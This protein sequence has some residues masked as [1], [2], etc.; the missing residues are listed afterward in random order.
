[1]NIWDYTVIGFYVLIMVIITLLTYSTKWKSIFSTSKKTKW[2]IA[3]I[4]LFMA[5][6]AVDGGQIV[7]GIIHE[8]GIWGLWI[9]WCGGIFT[10]IV[11][12]LFAPL[13]AKLNFITDNEFILFRYSGLGAKVLHQF[14]AVYV[15][16][17]IV[18]FLLS[19]QVL[20]FAHVLTQYFDIDNQVALY[21]SGGLLLLFALKN[22][23]EH[24]LKTD[25]FHTL[26]YVTLITVGGIIILSK[27][28]GWSGN[29]LLNFQDFFS[30]FIVQCCS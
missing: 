30:I 13:W 21:V 7:S 15:G 4:S 6:T 10:A 17:I 29:S 25:I 12:L 27:A 9:F 19:F 18:S 22:T 26:L 8:K 23:F 5:I 20:G 3:G 2:W 11:P 16:G 28:G 24:K 1:M 14:R